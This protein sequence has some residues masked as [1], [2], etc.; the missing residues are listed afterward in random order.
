M[1]S[2]VVSL[3][4]VLATAFFL[5]SSFSPSIA[6]AAVELSLLEKGSVHRS[7]D[8]G[9]RFDV[10]L[11]KM[12]FQAE[13]DEQFSKGYRPQQTIQLDGDLSREV[14]DLPHHM[15][16]RGAFAKVRELLNSSGFEVLFECARAACG[17]PQAWAMYTSPL[18]RGSEQEQYYLAVKAGDASYA[19]V[20][21][22]EIGGQARILVDHILAESAEPG[23][24]DKKLGSVQFPS[25]SSVLPSA[26]RRQL[27]K[28]AK[29]ILAATD[30]DKFMLVGHAD[31]T[32][33]LLRNL[34]LSGARAMAVREA[35]IKDFDVPSEQLLV[36]AYGNAKPRGALGSAEDRRVELSKSSAPARMLSQIA[37][38]QAEQD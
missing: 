13:A 4:S 38:D 15:R 33:G 11:G 32:G 31:Q 7:V 23:S 14:Y 30:E 34:Q 1:K 26:E 35:L 29:H 3:K 20:Y 37:I 27:A 10:P 25:G 12:I 8:I 9:G 16:A 2:S 5:G 17:K 36:T 6:L 21:A 22:K 18:V 24:A 19:Y 28:Y